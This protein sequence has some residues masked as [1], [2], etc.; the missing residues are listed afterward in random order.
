[1]LSADQLSGLLGPGAQSNRDTD[2]ELRPGCIWIGKTIAMAASIPDRNGNGTGLEYL[3]RTFPSHEPTA[4]VK[5]YPATKFTTPDAVGTKACIIA[6]AVNDQQTVVAT[7]KQS[8]SASPA[9]P[10]EPARTAL[11]LVLANLGGTR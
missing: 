9:D 10:C 6:L 1:M 7:V 3:N 2:T 4:S 5:G 8:M 11:E